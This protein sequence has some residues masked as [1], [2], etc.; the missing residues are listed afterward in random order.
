MPLCYTS[1]VVVKFR[2]GLTSEAEINLLRWFL[3]AEVAY[4]M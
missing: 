4:A 3:N 2:F 1:E